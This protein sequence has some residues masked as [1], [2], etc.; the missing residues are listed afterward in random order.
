MEFWLFHCQ[1]RE[2]RRPRN[3]GASG[4]TFAPIQPVFSVLAQ[5]CALGLPVVVMMNSR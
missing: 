4:A 2:Q 3:G 1:N 5:N